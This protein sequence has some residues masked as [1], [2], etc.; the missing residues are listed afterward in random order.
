MT[1]RGWVAVILAVGVATTVVGFS[2]AVLYDAVASSGPGLSDN[3]TQ[4]LTAALGGMVG[5]LGA[6]VGT[7]ASGGG[8]GDDVA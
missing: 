1:A 4:V 7:R 8:G 2:V 5:V 6:Y 3:A